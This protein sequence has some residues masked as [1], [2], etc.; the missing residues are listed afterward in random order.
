MSLLH[1]GVGPFPLGRHTFPLFDG[2]CSD[3][4]PGWVRNRVSEVLEVS[5][6]EGKLP[7]EMRYETWP[8]R[9]RI[10]MAYV[11]IATNITTTSPHV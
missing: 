1:A 3:K 7:C 11:K 2:S 10:A 5:L 9:W 6:V 8:K 4:N